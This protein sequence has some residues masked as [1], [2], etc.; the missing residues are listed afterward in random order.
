MTI[1][2]P[3]TG[4]NV[5]DLTHRDMLR[6]TAAMIQSRWPGRYEGD[7]AARLEQLAD[8]VAVES[9]KK[10]EMCELPHASIAEEEEC[11]RLR[12]IADT[13]GQTRE[14]S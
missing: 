4:M 3:H 1:I 6:S 5:R 9:R 12:V 11:E 14:A 13:Q 10:T 8:R 7:L 2:D